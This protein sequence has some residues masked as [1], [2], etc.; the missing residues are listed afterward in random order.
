[1][2]LRTPTAAGDL[3]G[4][5]LGVER[6]GGLMRLPR[7]P[8]TSGTTG[9]EP[10]SPAWCPEVARIRRAP[11]LRWPRWSATP[12]WPN[13]SLGFSTHLLVRSHAPAAAS[14]DRDPAGRATP[15]L[16]VRMG[17]SRQVHGWA[18][19][20]ED[21]ISDAGRGV[22]AD[23]VE[24]AVLNAVDE[25]DDDSCLSDRTWATLRESL[26]ERAR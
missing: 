12:I 15:R 17:S 13:R 26:D 4:R 11:A 1:M 3:A 24:I 22:A 21:E 7:Y 10:R 8:L 6:K 5:L 14:R 18:G 19:L 25:L 9:H 16:R 2:T 20:S 23:A